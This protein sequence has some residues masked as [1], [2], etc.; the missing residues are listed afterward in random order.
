MLAAVLGSRP[1]LADFSMSFFTVV[2]CDEN[3]GLKRQIRPK[4][5]EDNYGTFATPLG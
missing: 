1:K 3:L 2:E 4:G 5:G